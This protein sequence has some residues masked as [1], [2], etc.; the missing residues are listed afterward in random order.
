MA[1]MEN[2]IPRPH[3]GAYKRPGTHCVDAALENDKPERL[4]PFRFSTVQSYMLEMGHY[5]MRVIMDDALVANPSGQ[6][7][8]V[9][10]PYHANDLATLRFAQRADFMIF[11]HPN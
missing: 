9:S 6:A 5:R 11:T 4:I 10:T 7:V 2:F 3:G 1:L 8:V